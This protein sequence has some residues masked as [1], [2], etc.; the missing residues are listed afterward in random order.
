MHSIAE[1]AEYY[2]DVTLHEFA[3]FALS[4]ATY[5]WRIFQDVT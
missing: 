4:D 2:C 3:L 1:I 5:P